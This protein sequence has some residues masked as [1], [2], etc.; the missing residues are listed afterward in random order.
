[1]HLIIIT[2]VVE[3]WSFTLD[4]MFLLYKFH[5]GFR[6]LRSNHEVVHISANV[7]IVG[8]VLGQSNPNVF[9]ISGWFESIGP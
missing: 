1:M 4:D 9:V 8:F 3:R 2:K 7:L 5:D 6:M